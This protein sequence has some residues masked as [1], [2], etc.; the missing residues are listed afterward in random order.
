MKKLFIALLITVSLLTGCVKVSDKSVSDIFETIL[1]V[2]N[3]LSN[4]Y[5]EGYSFYL[6]QGLKIRDKND[7]NLTLENDKEKYYLYI[8][9]IAYYYKMENTFK[10]NGTHFYSK[11]FNHNNKTGYV[12]IIQENDRYFVVIMYN[13]AKIEAFIE[14]EDF[15]KSLMSISQILS[16]IKYNDAVINKYV[17]NKGEVYQEEKFNIFGSEIENDNFLKYEEEYGTYKEKIIVDDGIIDVEDVV[18]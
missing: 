15:N 11:K 14:K 9:T 13:Y 6:P 16:T 12:D 7:Y 3:N 5:M 1:Y 8:D 4:T 18:D 2:D 17:G 10:E